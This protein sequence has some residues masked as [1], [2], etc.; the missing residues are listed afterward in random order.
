MGTVRDWGDRR[1]AVPFLDFSGNLWT[2]TLRTKDSTMS[3]LPLSHSY[4][5]Y[6]VTSVDVIV[7]RT[8]LRRHQNDGFLT[9]SVFNDTPSCSN[10]SH[11][12]PG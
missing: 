9:L 2:E 6:L 12:T 1:S 11:E 3:T 8:T 5:V 10:R 7:I 4:S